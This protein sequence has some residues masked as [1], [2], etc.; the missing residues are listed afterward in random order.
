VGVEAEMH[1][2]G[3]VRAIAQL[4][5]VLEVKPAV[6]AVQEEEFKVLRALLVEYGLLHEL[7]HLLDVFAEK[8]CKMSVETDDSHG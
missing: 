2:G 4:L 7:F 1:K 3:N 5:Q 8:H 6:F